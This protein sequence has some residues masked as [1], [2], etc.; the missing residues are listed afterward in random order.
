MSTPQPPEPPSGDI[1]PRSRGSHRAEK[2]A[3]TSLLLPLLGVLGVLAALGLAGYMLLTSGDDE[4]T[5]ATPRPPVTTPATTASGEPTDE[6]SDEPSD[7]QP[8]SPP[9]RKPRHRAMTPPR[10]A[11]AA[12]TAATTGATTAATTVPATETVSRLSAPFRSFRSM[13]STKPAS[14]GWRRKPPASS[15]RVDGMSRASTTGAGRCQRTPSTTTRAGATRQYA[16]R[17]SSPY[18]G[19]VWPATSP[20]PGG[21]LTVILAETDRK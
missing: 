3:S 16:S 8:I 13:C 11:T 15:A 2:P 5:G 21:A 20:M 6:P 1:P 17:D 10:T 4:G 12:T 7:Q 14:P 18:I 19:R 9:T